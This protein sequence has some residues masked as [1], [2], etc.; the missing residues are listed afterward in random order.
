MPYPSLCMCA[1]KINIFEKN[2]CAHAVCIQSGYGTCECPMKVC[3]CV[4][5][6]THMGIS[7]IRLRSLDKSHIPPSHSDC[8]PCKIL[9]H[10]EMDEDGKY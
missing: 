6:C 5:V 7:K 1:H 8:K 9:P 2:V 4:R 3:V 10:F